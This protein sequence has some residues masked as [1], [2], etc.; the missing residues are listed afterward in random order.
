MYKF[1]KANSNDEVSVWCVEQEV[2]SPSVDEGE[3][4]PTYG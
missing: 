1:A 2:E 4:V 3:M